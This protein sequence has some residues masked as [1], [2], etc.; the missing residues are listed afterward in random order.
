[1]NSDKYFFS[2]NKIEAIKNVLSFEEETEHELT[3]EEIEFQ[4]VEF[5]YEHGS[6]NDWKSKLTECGNFIFYDISHDD[7]SSCKDRIYGA[8][9]ELS[10]KF[11]G[12]KRYIIVPGYRTSDRIKILFRYDRHDKDEIENFRL[13]PENLLY[14]D[15]PSLKKYHHG[16]EDLCS[17][18]GYKILY[19]E[20]NYVLS[21]VKREILDEIFPSKGEYIFRSPRLK[22][23]K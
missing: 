10:K 11:K 19:Y 2:S 22:T 8:L 5:E 18:E 13:I 15:L 6:K 9:K 20:N 21:R 1:M 17:H 3:K 7:L 23:I 12:I 4:N 14:Y 16:L